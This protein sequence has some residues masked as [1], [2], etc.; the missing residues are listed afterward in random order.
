MLV[1][2]ATIRVKAGAGGDGIV[3]FRR[4][5]FVP[6]GGPDGGNGGQGGSVH[7]VADP[8]LHTLLDFRF[9]P[10]YTADSGRPGGPSRSTGRNGKDLR[11]RVPVGTRLFENEK[12]L[13]DL[14]RPEQQF[15]VAQGGRGGRGNASFATPTN[16]TPRK[17]TPGRVGGERELLLELKLMADVG[18]V[19]L[20]NAGKSTLLSVLTAARPKIAS[21]PF[22]TLQPNLGIVR[23]AEF[24]SFVLADIPGLIEGASGGK[25]LGH[26]FLRH[27]ERTR[28]L[29]YLVDCTSETPEADIQVLKSELAQWNPDLPN[30]PSLIVL[31]KT[32]LLSGE[33]VPEGPWTMA[34]SSATHAGTDEL[35]QEMWRMLQ[36]APEPTSFRAPGPLPSASQTEREE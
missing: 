13:V 12:L 35:A 21:Y 17:C 30:R 28:V 11:I 22:T 16:R 26:E 5:A 2:R 6:K 19:G 29:V 24:A 33:P 20:P 23:P 10:N 4:E 8:Q 36:D 9:K 3:S 25:G 18:L 1:D 14:N 7:V 32:D 31:S 27:I 34:V 15:C